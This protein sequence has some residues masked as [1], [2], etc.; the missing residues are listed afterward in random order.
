M[1]IKPNIAISENGFVFDP[2]SG[3][4]F[5]LNPIASE[6]IGHLKDNRDF[7]EMKKDLLDKYDVDETTLERHFYDFISMLKQ[8]DLLDEQQDG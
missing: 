5:T 6:I 3:E 8:Y 7:E 4:S 1:K 2:N